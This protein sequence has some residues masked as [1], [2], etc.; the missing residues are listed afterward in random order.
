MSAKLYTRSWAHALVT[1]RT[2][3]LHHRGGVYG[4]HCSG[5][6]LLSSRRLTGCRDLESHFGCAHGV[7]HS[8][9]PE[10]PEDINS[11]YGVPQ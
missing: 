2:V 5:L 6:S 1:A 11:I 3:D 7:D 4:A 8:G 9:F 10:V